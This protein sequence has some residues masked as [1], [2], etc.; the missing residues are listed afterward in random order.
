MLRK[1]KMLKKLNIQS[2]MT[3]WRMR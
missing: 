1:Y 3:P 2:E